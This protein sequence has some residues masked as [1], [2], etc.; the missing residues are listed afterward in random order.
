MIAN[1]NQLLN[2]TMSTQSLA[3]GA[4]LMS[5]FGMMASSNSFDTGFSPMLDAHTPI[6]DQPLSASFQQVTPVTDGADLGLPGVD[7]GF[8]IAADPVFDGGFGG[9]VLPQAGSLDTVQPMLE[10]DFAPLADD[11]TPIA[12]NDADLPVFAAGDMI[13]MPGAEAMA[14]LAANEAVASDDLGNILSE[15]LMGGDVD[16]VDAILAN[17]GE[18]GLFGEGGLAAIAPLGDFASFNMGFEGGFTFAT[19]DIMVMEAMV[20]HHDA[21]MSA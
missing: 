12:G 13:V 15:A 21:M 3:T 8:G 2:S 14:N 19:Q 5:G 7:G 4:A 20:L 6:F 10:P 9:A 17:L 18:G 16:P 11:M 1:D